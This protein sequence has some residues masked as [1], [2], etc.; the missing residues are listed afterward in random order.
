MATYPNNFIKMTFGG[1]LA[2]GQDEWNCGINLAA[3]EPGSPSSP[4]FLN[5]AAFD[6]YVEQIS[7]DITTIMSRF[8]SDP[9]MT[10]QANIKLDYVKFALINKLG[11]YEKEP[12]IFE[13]G[14][15][16]GNDTSSGYIPQISQ[17]I[18]L[19]SDK[20]RDPGKYNRFYLPISAPRTANQYKIT[21]TAERAERVA[22]LLEALR[23]AVTVGGVTKA[24]LPCA[25]SSST[26]ETE[27]YRPI[28]IVKVGDVYDTQRR[29]RNKISENYGL[30]N[31]E[32]NPIPVPPEE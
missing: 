23:R 26:R 30:H 7:P 28:T 14:S 8:F 31:V 9:I 15:V 17:V 12:A 21:N 10:I 13:L 32:L 19:Q 3:S 6:S 20:W 25:V 2:A 29:R 24:V 11:E 16:G 27:D 22:F 1:T 4:G 5:T 18:T